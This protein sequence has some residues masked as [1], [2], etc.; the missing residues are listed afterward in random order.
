MTIH[1]LPERFRYVVVEGAIGVG[2]TSLAK[3]LAQ[4]IG[5]ETMFEDPHAN[6]FLAGFY[7]DMERHAFATQMFFLRQRVGQLEALSAGRVP[8]RPVIS[9]FLLEK[10]ALFARLTLNESEYRLYEDYFELLAPRAPTPDLVI[11]LQ[12]PVEALIARVRRR[13]EAFERGISEAY[14]RDLDVAYTRFFHEYTASPLLIVNSEHLNFVDRPQD[15]ELLL[16]RITEVRGGREFFN[17]G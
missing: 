2:K 15:F 1:A 8:E 5:A 7:R 6:P 10:D 9:D 13:G 4:R 17:R 16:R 11:Y 12:A 3:L 14:L